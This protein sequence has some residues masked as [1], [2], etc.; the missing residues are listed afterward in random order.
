MAWIPGLQD[1]LGFPAVG[2]CPLD[3]AVT[4]LVEK[5][6]EPIVACTTTGHSGSAEGWRCLIPC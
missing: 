5:Q 3:L 4:D 6:Q 2:R 1:G